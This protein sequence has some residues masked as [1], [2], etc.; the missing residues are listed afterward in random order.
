MFADGVYE[1]IRSYAGRL[2]CLAEHMERLRR[3]LAAVRIHVRDPGALEPVFQE[4]L[5]RNDLRQCDATVYLQI[6]RGV[7]G[8][9]H[10]F[11]AEPVPPTIYA[12]A[13]RAA[14]PI[15]QMERGVTAI[16]V[17]DIRWARC[18]IKSIG[19][20]PNVLARQAA[21]E[22]GAFEAIFVRDGVITEGTHTNIAGVLSGVVVTHALTNRVLDGITRAI[23]LRLCQ[24]LAIP[25]SETFLLVSQ[26]AELDEL[27]LIGTTVE[28]MPVT[29]VDGKPIGSAKP[30]PVTRRLQAAFQE[31]VAARVPRGESKKY[32]L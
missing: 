29:S 15:E 13:N 2:F 7:C 10:Q 6:T 27:F 9:R 24:N 3:S 31:F 26:L 5:T 28:V 11:P 32:E 18:D 20:L 4:L 25:V 21:T 16:T 17:P 19:L 1:M 8:R 14:R 23:V 30:G 22:Q 12:E